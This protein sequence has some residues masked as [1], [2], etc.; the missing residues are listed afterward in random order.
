M[1][2]S[3]TKL[4]AVNVVK[5]AKFNPPDRVLER[6]L[7]ALA[8]DMKTHGQLQPISITADYEVGDGHRRLAAAK[9]LGWRQINATIYKDM[10]VEEL[11]ISL[12]RNTRPIKPASWL[13]AT[14]NGL[15]LD[16]VPKQYRN[17]IE[18]ARIWVGEDNLRF[19]SEQM[20]STDVI[21][22]T[23]KLAKYVGDES[24]EMKGRILH[25]LVKHRMHLTAGRYMSRQEASEWLL[26]AIEQ[27]R[28]FELV[29]GWRLA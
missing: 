7:V 28:P 22:S 15:D 11:W 1:H 9:L 13:Y 6:N 20:K 24:D 27:D 2:K 17:L 26:D 16:L 23:I 19:L 3:E 18:Q 10:T 12:N 14:D 8:E 25:W 29:S 4:V 21:R 5:P